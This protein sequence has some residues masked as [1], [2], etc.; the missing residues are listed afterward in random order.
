MHQAPPSSWE[1]IKD[2][3][4]AGAKLLTN[5]HIHLNTAKRFL[6]EVRCTAR[7]FLRTAMPA[8]ALPIRCL[9]VAT[10]HTS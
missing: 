9:T 8:F 1:D 5:N 6:E 3:T 4:P 2:L 10:P 7:P